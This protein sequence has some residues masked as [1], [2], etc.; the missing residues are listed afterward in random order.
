[1]HTSTSDIPY[2]RHYYQIDDK[3][4]HSYEEMRS[5]WIQHSPKNK[6][7]VVHDNTDVLRTSRGQGF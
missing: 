7:V 3:I 1:M 5:W 2:D 6:T 4:F